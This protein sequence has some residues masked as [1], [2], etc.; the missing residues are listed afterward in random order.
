MSKLRLLSLV[1][2]A[3]GVLTTSPAL[4]TPMTF[5]IDVE[6][7]VDNGYGLPAGT[8]VG[9]GSVTM[10]VPDSAPAGYSGATLLSL[11]LML[12]ADTWTLA[13]ATTPGGVAGVLLDGAPI[14]VVYFGL[15]ASGHVVALDFDPEQLGVADITEPEAN[16]FALGTYA[17]AEAPS[18]PE[19]GAALL[20]GAGL[21]VAAARVRRD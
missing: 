8:Y 15:N 16:R 21:L 20:F 6:V 10:D 12:G 13:D 11:E 2:I 1:A 17:L 4:A 19:P 14:G 5:G 3:V 18:V 9:A 7:L